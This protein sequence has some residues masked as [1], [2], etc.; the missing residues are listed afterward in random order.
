MNNRAKFIN[1]YFK[2]IV[3]YC[4]NLRSKKR[5]KVMP[6]YKLIEIIFKSWLNWVMNQN[7]NEDYVWV[8]SQMTHTQSDDKIWFPPQISFLETNQQLIGNQWKMCINSIFVKSFWRK[9]DEICHT[10][11]FQNKK[12]N[13]ALPLA[14]PL[15]LTIIKLS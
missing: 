14:L 10:F 11:V 13:L 3:F 5:W 7:E 15:Q 2:R 6:W 1:C 8:N 4:N 9:H 12:Q